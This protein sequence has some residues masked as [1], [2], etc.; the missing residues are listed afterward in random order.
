MFG[1]GGLTGIPLAF[2]SADLYLPTTYY[3]IAHFHYIVAPAQSR[4]FAGV[5]YCSPRRRPKDERF[6]GQSAFLP[7][8]ICMNVI[9]FPMFLQ[10]MAADASAVVRWRPQGGPCRTITPFGIDR[11]QWN[12][13]ISWPPGIMGLAKSRFIINFFL[14]QLARRKSDDNPCEAT[15]LEWT[16]PS[17][18]P[19]GILSYTRRLSRAL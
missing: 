7:T 16:A 18:P 13:P 14:E 19:H 6:S 8:L 1:I 4:A 12:H 9:F 2:N 15:T 5:Y 11:F 10:G 3:I 17:P